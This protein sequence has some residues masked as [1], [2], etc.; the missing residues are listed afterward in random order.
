MENKSY[1]VIINGVGKNITREEDKDA[2]E[3]IFNNYKTDSLILRTVGQI[4]KFQDNFYIANYQR[5][6]RWG[7]DEE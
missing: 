2:I 1:E 6:Y 3:K 7:K 5:G 4:C